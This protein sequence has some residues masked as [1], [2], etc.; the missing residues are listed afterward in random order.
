MDCLLSSL[1]PHFLHSLSYFPLSAFSTL[2]ISTLPAHFTP[3]TP[4]S[5]LCTPSFHSEPF[6]RL[7]LNN[8]YWFIY[9]F[10]VTVLSR[11]GLGH[12]EQVAL[13]THDFLDGINKGNPIRSAVSNYL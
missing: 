12:K 3:R 8:P 11:L 2:F 5:A 10:L 9:S 7:L 13:W 4:H 6:Q 1:N